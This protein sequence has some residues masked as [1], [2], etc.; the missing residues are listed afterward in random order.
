MSDPLADV[1]SQ[2]RPR[3]V[4]AKV[5]SG[6]GRW[7]VTYERYGHASF[8]VLIDGRC[9]LRIDGQSPLALEAGDFLLLPST[10]AFTL[11]SLAPATPV[12]VRP[13]ALPARSGDI[14]HGRRS[15]APDV[16]MLGGYFMFDSPDAHWLLSLLPERVHIRGIERL[17]QLVRLVGDEANHDRAGRELILTR[18]VEVLLVESLRTVSTPEAPA[19]LL[20]GLADPRIAP[21]LRG[22]HGD[23]TRAWTMPLLARE[24]GMSRS[25][26]FERFTRT[27]GCTPGAYLLAWRMTL[28]KDLLQRGEL[29][30]AEIAERVG[31]RA[32]ATFSTAFA[33]HVGLPPRRYASS[34]RVA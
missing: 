34:V 30:V 23:P 19:G 5:V 9:R 31:Y 4:F 24:V 10:P 28:A 26:L 1:I 14:R 17:S 25:A 21:A 18:L 33:R 15:G 11:S 13:P 29:G 20:R 3:A 8:C 22:L 32:P 27:V 6:A 16:R 12:Q 2:L 7:A